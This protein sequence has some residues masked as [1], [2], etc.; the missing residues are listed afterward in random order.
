MFFTSVDF[1]FPFCSLPAGLSVFFLK[2][3]IVGGFAVELGQ[4]WGWEGGDTHHTLFIFSLVKGSQLV[5]LPN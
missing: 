2:S 4:G 1:V 3:D 5:F